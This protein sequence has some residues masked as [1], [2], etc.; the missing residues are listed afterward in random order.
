MLKNIDPLLTPE[1][2]FVLAAMGHGDDI[3]VVDANFPADSVAHG[4]CHGRVV[5]LAGVSMPEAVGAILSVLPLDEFVDAPVRRMAVDGTTDKLA[6]VQQEVQGI[7][8]AG[9][10]RHWPMGA[11]ERFA[12]YEAA[13]GSYAVILTGERRFFGNVLIKKGA[14][15]PGD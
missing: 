4:T 5:S 3:A 12:F 9:A 8:D 6:E 10:G 13:R 7:I 1:L 15:P 14:L 11:L 2:L